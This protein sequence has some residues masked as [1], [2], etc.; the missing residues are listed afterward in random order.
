MAAISKPEAAFMEDSSLNFFSFAI[1]IVNA[2][3]YTEV[4]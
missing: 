3:H 2:T 1:V 4:M